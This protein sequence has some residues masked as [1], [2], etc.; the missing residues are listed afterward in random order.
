M[1]WFLERFGIEP[2]GSKYPMLRVYKAVVALSPV[3]A[4]EDDMLGQGLIRIGEVAERVGQAP[5]TLL[6]KLRTGKTAFPALYVFGPNRHMMLRAQVEEMLASPR[7]PWHALDPIPGHAVPASRLAR[8][9]KVPQAQIDALLADKR[10]LPAHMITRGRVGFIVADAAHRL[11]SSRSGEA[12]AAEDAPQPAA[13]KDRSLSAALPGTAPG[14]LFSAAAK[15][16]ARHARAPHTCTGS[17]F[18]ARRGDGAHATRV[19]AK[20]LG[21]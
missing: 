3:G 4:I 21:T 18:H 15:Q 19:E 2:L 16:A 6:K 17:G 11:R 10:D 12:A 9:L 5:D 1:P 20:L 7:N 8:T 13:I 14:G